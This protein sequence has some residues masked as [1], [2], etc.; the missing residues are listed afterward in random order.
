MLIDYNNCYGELL[1]DGF[2]MKWSMIGGFYDICYGW[3]R[4]ESVV[5]VDMKYI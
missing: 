2:D 5:V 4:L 1:R 3:L